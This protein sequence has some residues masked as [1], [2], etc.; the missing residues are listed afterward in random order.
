MSLY[1][2][3]PKLPSFNVFFLYSLQIIIIYNVT[4][5][6]DVLAQ[7]IFFFFVINVSSFRFKP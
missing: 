1:L 2:I 7:E 4:T 3:W 6:F 5:L